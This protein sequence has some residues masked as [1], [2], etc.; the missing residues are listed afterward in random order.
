METTLYKIDRIYIIEDICYVDQIYCGIS[1]QLHTGH[2]NFCII[3][4][5]LFNCCAAGAR[6]TLE[7]E[8]WSK[9]KD[10]DTG[11]VISRL[12]NCPYY[13]RQ[14]DKVEKIVTVRGIVSYISGNIE[15]NHIK[16]KGNEQK[17]IFLVD[18]KYLVHWIY[19][20]V[21][22]YKHEIEIE[23]DVNPEFYTDTNFKEII[24]IKPGLGAYKKDI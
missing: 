22:S 16:F 19:N 24:N 11:A 21:C 5:E 3:F 20:V 4:T 14:P 12:K 23:I 1:L 9:I 17:Y 7:L 6:P 8:N 15:K 18:R 2:E 10:A 13:E